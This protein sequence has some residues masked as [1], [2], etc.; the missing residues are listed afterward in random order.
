MSKTRYELLLDLSVIG[1]LFGW[2][3]FSNDKQL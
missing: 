2:R 1:M 3:L